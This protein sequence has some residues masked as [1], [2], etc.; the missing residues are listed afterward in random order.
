MDGDPKRRI[1]RP[2]PRTSEPSQKIDKPFFLK[3]CHLFKTLSTWDLRSIAKLTRL[4]EIKRD[5]TVFREGEEGSSLYIVVSGRFEAYRG[6]WNNKT[7]LAYL[8]QGAYFGEISLITQ[9]PHSASIRALSDSL[10]LEIP[11]ENFE[12]ILKTHASVSLEISRTLSTR[13]VAQTKS[14]EEGRPRLFRPEVFSVLSLHNEPEHTAFSINLAASL[15]RET[16]HPAVLVDMSPGGRAVSDGLKISANLP[17]RFFE[18]FGTDLERVLSDHLV[19]HRSGIRLLSLAY[20]KTEKYT[21]DFIIHLFNR[22]AEDFRFIIADLP[23]G[24]DETVAK[25][26]GQSDAVFFKTDND[27]NTLQEAKQIIAELEKTIHTPGDRIKVVMTDKTLGMV[28][29]R[30]AL[31]EHFGEKDCFCL[32]GAALE[33]PGTTD[34]SPAVISR[35]GSEYARKVRH[36]ARKIS[37]NLVGVALGSGAALGYAHIGVL[38]VLE[39]E[40]IPVD[41]ISGSSMGAMI[42]SFYAAGVGLER[43]EELSRMKL[44]RLLGLVDLTLFL[45]KGL[46]PGRAIKSFFVKQL[47]NL[48]FEDTRIPLLLVGAD[49]DDRAVRVFD[50]GPVA[51]G[52][53]VSISIPAV[54]HP[55]LQGKNALIDGGILDPLPVRPLLDYGADK[56]IA[57]DVLPTPDDV[58]KKNYHR[59][60]T[61]QSFEHR[62]ATKNIW[63]RTAYRLRTR[64]ENSFHA[65]CLD[66]VVNSI[67]AMEHEMANSTSAEADV[68]IRPSAPLIHWSEFRRSA[69]LIRIG[70]EAAESAADRLR[71]LVKPEPY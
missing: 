25:T 52:L 17:S 69:E 67:Q 62:I 70:E 38:K 68:L 32:P 14:G 39:R 66:V 51:E 47:G 21:P 35:P 46:V 2:T 34:P 30:E 71:A 50:S 6:S 19:T 65:N 12:N 9:K 3:R 27:F 20:D 55:V 43:M 64:I 57:V 31:R 40:N 37:R 18:D 63:A 44:W 10:A 24:M 49:I 11:K 33:D 60:R 56:V 42:A 28:P 7:T 23:E 29:S 8:R 59:Q 16:G 48:M 26:V 13:L 5:E 22:L 58:R 4:V 41:V 1:A 54:F 53:R 61:R 15:V 36:I 45:W